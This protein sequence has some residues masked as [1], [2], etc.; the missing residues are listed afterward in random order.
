M[1]IT[2]DSLY[3]P[4]L[5]MLWTHRKDEADNPARTIH[6]AF[7]SELWR[8]R[9]V[10]QRIVLAAHYLLWPVIVLGATGYFTWHNGTAIRRRGGKGVLR[11]AGEQV[12]LAARYGI[13]SP[14]Y[15][16][17]ELHRPENFARADAYLTR[18]ETKANLY[19]LLKERVEKTGGERLN[20]KA[21]F[22]EIC[23]RAGIPTPQV[24]AVARGGR[25]EAPERPA[26]QGA[27]STVET[28]PARDLFIKPL[29]GKGGRGAMRARYRG[30]QRY[31]LSDGQLLSERQL[32][33]HLARL[34]E[35]RA[36]L[37]QECLVNHPEITDLCADALSC[38]RTVTVRTPTGAFEVT[39]AAFRMAQRSDTVVDG[40]HRGG[41]VAK[42]DLDSG[43]LGPATDLGFKPHV[44][45]VRANPHSGVQI[46]GRTLPMWDEL[47]A[48]AVKAH[49][50]FPY[51]VA[52]GWDIA[53]TA[54][55]PVVVEGNGSPCV[56]IIQRVDM[57]MG[58]GRFGEALAH[59]VRVALG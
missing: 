2:D 4:P 45:W 9:N 17:F 46:A 36:L 34:S 15:Y 55:G 59:H 23:T 38:V 56:D 18:Q 1:K 41:L 58:N 5:A 6:S 43:V 19:E 30:A 8:E 39:N 25:L 20:D 26:H 10:R 37:V 7:L 33:G 31:R 22:A 53:I 24:V 47:K 21:L 51:K 3:C 28:L 29:Q 27:G 42:V 35:R 48:V 57:P 13:L 32:I 54:D 11:Q 52:V 14:W 12:W 16:M 40:L 49:S 50:A 44:G